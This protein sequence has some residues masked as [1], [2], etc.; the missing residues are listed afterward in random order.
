LF[1]LIAGV[2]L[3]ATLAAPSSSNIDDKW[4]DYTQPLTERNHVMHD[5]PVSLYQGRFYVEKDNKLRYCIRYREA[6]HSYTQ[7]NG[8]HHGAYQFTKA[9]A[10]GVSW[11]IQKELRAT[12][13][14]KRQ[15]LHLGRTLRSNDIAQWSPFW[16]DFAFWIVWDHGA[17]KQHWA[18][19]N[20]AGAC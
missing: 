13:T 2:T 8:P 17:G 16:Q 9:L 10:V 11:M 4:L 14:P 12:G 3:A 5:S 18:A 15:A 20:Y 7:D 1:T 6:R 19:T